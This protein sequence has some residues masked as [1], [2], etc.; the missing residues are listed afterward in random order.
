MDG[1]VMAEL[2]LDLSGKRAWHLWS[3]S[4]AVF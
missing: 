1:G 3:R 4:L 2:A